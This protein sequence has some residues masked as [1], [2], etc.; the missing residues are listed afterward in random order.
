M[1]AS[2]EVQ[3]NRSDRPYLYLFLFRFLEAKK[4]AQKNSTQPLLAE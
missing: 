2:T 4:T 3:G 1:V